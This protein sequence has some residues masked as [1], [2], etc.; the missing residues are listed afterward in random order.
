LEPTTTNTDCL[1]DVVSIV[2]TVAVKPT[3]LVEGKCVD[4]I[5]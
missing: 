5:G 3:G 1:I 4:L 2:E